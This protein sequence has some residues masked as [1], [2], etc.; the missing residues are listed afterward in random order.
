[1]SKEKKLKAEIVFESDETRVLRNKIRHQEEQEELDEK[2]KLEREQERRR[3]RIS[4]QKKIK[5]YQS[6]I[7][8]IAFSN[9][10]ADRLHTLK[11]KSQ[12]TNSDFLN[13]LLDNFEQNEKKRKRKKKEINKR[14]FIKIDEKTKFYL[15]PLDLINSIHNQ[16]IRKIKEYRI[17]HCCKI[18]TINEEENIISIFNPSN[19]MNNNCVSK[20]DLKS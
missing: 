16:K 17:N 4:N 14:K 20:M 2:K 18:E 1:M 8:R 3:R 13:I 15:F 7:K 5:K 10:T 19:T 11:K 12:K 9:E 6:M